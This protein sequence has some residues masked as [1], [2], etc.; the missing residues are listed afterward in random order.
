[1]FNRLCLKRN[2]HTRYKPNPSCSNRIKFWLGCAYERLPFQDLLCA[3][4]PTPQ[5][6]LQDHV[7]IFPGTGM[8]LIVGRQYTKGFKC[9]DIPWLCAAVATAVHAEG[10]RRWTIVNFRPSES[11]RCPA[12][13]WDSPV[14]QRPNPRIQSLRYSN[15]I[16]ILTNLFCRAEYSAFSALSTS[17]SLVCFLFCAEAMRFQIHS[18][19]LTSEMPTP[20]SNPTLHPSQRLRG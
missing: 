3:T 11:F 15:R 8:N 17:F 9:E 5:F 16:H 19:D 20:K 14:N 2:V 7:A 18:S 4:L 12:W 10:F 6:F 1:M 13:T